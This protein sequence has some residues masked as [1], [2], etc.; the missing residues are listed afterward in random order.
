M[1]IQETLSKIQ[2]ELKAK[3]GQTN[4]FGKYSYRSAED[5]LEALKP[6]S[7]KYGVSVIITE[8]L[9]TEGVLESQATM[10][11]LEGESIAANAIVGIDMNQKGM[12]LPQK[13]GSAS[14]YAKKYAL[15]NLFAID[16][17]A[18]ADATN[19][20][21]KKA[22][23]SKDELKENSASYL[24]V[25]TALKSKKFT[26]ADVEAKYTLS[27]ELKEKLKNI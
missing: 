17:T 23:I 26:V 10:T 18:D 2:F 9:L 8:K 12:S 5:V 16:N 11:N 13:Y 7:N 3:K 20:H 6:L 15:G 1:K 25:V 14:S 19:T 22:P 27:S 21:G 24:K 4:A